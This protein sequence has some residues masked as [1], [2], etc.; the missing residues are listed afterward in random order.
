MKNK[1]IEDEPEFTNLL[2]DFGL[3]KS[4]L[5]LTLENPADVSVLDRILN[6]QDGNLTSSQRVW[7]Q[8]LIDRNGRAWNID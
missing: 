5:Q 3:R 8:T 4:V 2:A 1:N 6:K 7:I